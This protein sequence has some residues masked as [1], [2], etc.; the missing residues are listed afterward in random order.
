MTF[1]NKKLCLYSSGKVIPVP[2][3]KAYKGNRGKAPFIPNLSARLMS[4]HLHNLAAYLGRD[5][6]IPTE[7][8]TGWTPESVWTFWEEK[9][10]S[11][12]PRIET[13]NIHTIT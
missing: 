2:A 13:L 10:L 6:S 5:L 1:V 3:M 8:V 9:V 11:P 7:A 4:C 12:L